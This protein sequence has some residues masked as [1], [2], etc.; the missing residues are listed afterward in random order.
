MYVD[1]NSFV[2]AFRLMRATRSSLAK[3][4][5]PCV[6]LMQN[7]ML[8]GCAHVHIDVQENDLHDR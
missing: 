5:K 8:L 6:K 3:G 4:C 2:Y 1:C 7:N